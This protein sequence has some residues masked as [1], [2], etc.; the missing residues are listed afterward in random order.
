MGGRERQRSVDSGGAGLSLGAYASG[1]TESGFVG[2]LAVDC[3]SLFVATEFL[4]DREFKLPRH[5]DAV[6]L[7]TGTTIK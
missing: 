1:D 2:G 7:S 5:V 4:K 3:V 6:T